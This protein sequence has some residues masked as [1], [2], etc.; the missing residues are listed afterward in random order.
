MEIAKNV[1]EFL[2]WCSHEIGRSEQEMFNIDCWNE[3]ED[4]KVESPIEQIL[5][6]ALKAI[7]KLNNIDQ[8]DPQEIRGELIVVGISIDPQF[9]IG[10]YRVDFKISY[11]AFLSQR[12]HIK[13]P[14]IQQGENRAIVSNVIVECDSQ[15][16]HDRTE[17]ERRYE[18][19]RDRFLQSNGY[20]VFRYTGS[21]IIKRPM[22]I[23]REIISF[24]TGISEDC[25]QIDSN[26]E[27]EQ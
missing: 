21:E 11:G 25:F 15:Q 4:L 6:T 9:Q 19:Q 22:E 10:K 24:V 27:D 8:A 14:C 3:F 1:N 5:Y 20:V 17:K 7:C 23:A 12:D 16:F 26:F 18:K 2:R 13:A